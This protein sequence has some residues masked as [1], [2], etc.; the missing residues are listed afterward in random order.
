MKPSNDLRRCPACGGRKFTGKY[1]GPYSETEYFSEGTEHV[2]I[3]DHQ[4]AF[5][6]ALFDACQQANEL[7][8]DFCLDELDLSDSLVCASEFSATVEL[9]CSS[10]QT[11]FELSSSL[12]EKYVSRG[13][14]PEVDKVRK[15]MAEDDLTKPYL[16][17]Y[18]IVD[19][20]DP[21]KLT[22]LQINW[23]CPSC[24]GDVYVQAFSIIQVVATGNER[25]KILVE[26]EEDGTPH[27]E[28]EFIESST[29]FSEANEA[30]HQHSNTRLSIGCCGAY[31]WEIGNL[32]P[33]LDFLDP[34]DLQVFRD[35]G[36]LV[37]G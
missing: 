26:F 5:I 14:G 23:S 17:T 25:G 28:I 22:P 37:S 36:I 30:D 29:F 35:L 12:I 16:K 15:R 13:M 21:I 18:A 9:S 1:W 24:K 19:A 10:C 3:R 11:P 31:C 4:G 8:S 33:Y 20:D 34:K 27:V 6:D 32:D 2:L 7:S